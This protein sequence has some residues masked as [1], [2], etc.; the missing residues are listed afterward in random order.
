[1]LSILETEL[2][3]PLQYKGRPCLLLTSAKLS[4]ESFE[5]PD[6]HPREDQDFLLWCTDTRQLIS[7]PEIFYPEVPVTK[8]FLRLSRGK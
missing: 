1:M 4:P 3:L 8:G 5:M 2:T 7:V 6:H